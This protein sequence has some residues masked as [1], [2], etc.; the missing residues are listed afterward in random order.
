MGERVSLNQENVHGLWYL[1]I[2]PTPVPIA[3]L[4]S[5]AGFT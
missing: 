2:K 3:V 4:A 5:E 1:Q